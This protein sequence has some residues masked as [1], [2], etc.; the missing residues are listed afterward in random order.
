MSLP[1][2]PALP[3]TPLQLAIIPEE[4]IRDTCEKVWDMLDPEG[5]GKIDKVGF[6]LICSDRLPD[7]A[8]DGEVMME[9]YLDLSGDKDIDLTRDTFMKFLREEQDKHPDVHDKFQLLRMFIED[10]AK[11]YMAD[12]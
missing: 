2:T 5:T 1:A 9:A 6:Y 11:E 7:L 12:G 4:D 3:P 10:K 8:E